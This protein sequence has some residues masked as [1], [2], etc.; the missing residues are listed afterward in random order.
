MTLI[1]AGRY[2]LVTIRRE[3]NGSWM[4]RIGRNLTDAV[5]GMLKSKHYLI[6]DRGL[7]FT[8]EFLKIVGETGIA[9]VKNHR[10][11]VRT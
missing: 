7:F 4:N 10:G 3:L 5:G 9:V 1:S 11:G 2:R 6:D 8:P